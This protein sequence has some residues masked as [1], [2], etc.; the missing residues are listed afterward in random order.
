MVGL[1]DK[2]K[3]GDKSLSGG[4]KQRLAVALALINDPDLIFLD[5]PTH[6]P[7]PAG[8]AWPVGNDSRSSVARQ[9]R[10][11]DHALHGRAEQLCDR[12]AIIDHGRIIELDSP[13]ALINKHFRETAIEFVPLSEASHEQFGALPAVK[14]T[15]VEN[16][17]VTL[18][19]IDVPRT[20]A[21]LFDLVSAQALTFKDM[22]CA[23]PHWKTC[24]ETSRTEDRE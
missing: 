19:S 12:V 1:K 10:A 14:Q 18:Y 6:W 9:D 17:H 2:A 3:S 13:A 8:A 24:F 4:Q 15:L 7:R 21:G 20:M 22:T 11:A 23:R 5:E 16:S